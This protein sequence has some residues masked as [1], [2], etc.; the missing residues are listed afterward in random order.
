MY[1]TSSEEVLLTKSSSS[2]SST[3]PPSYTSKT[4]V[5]YW[6][7]YSLGKHSICIAY[8]RYLPQIT[9]SYPL[10][11]CP[12]RLPDFCLESMWRQWIC[13]KTTKDFSPPV[14]NALHIRISPMKVRGLEAR[15]AV[16]HI[17]R[18]YPPANHGTYILVQITFRSIRNTNT[19][20]LLPI[21]NDHRTG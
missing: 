5:K 6:M 4:I 13:Y 21:Q 16:T 14:T 3:S 2:S 18:K 10:S 9:V 11:I 12:L 8:L 19:F 1:S 17:S 15:A 7:N 20:A